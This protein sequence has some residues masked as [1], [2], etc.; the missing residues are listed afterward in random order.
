MIRCRTCQQDLIAY[1]QRKL[2]P[3]RRRQI[4]QHLEGCESCYRVYREYQHLAEELERTVPLIGRGYEPVSETRWLSSS[5]RRPQISSYGLVALVMAFMLIIPLTMGRPGLALAAATQPTP[6]VIVPVTPNNHVVHDS[7]T[8]VA[9]NLTPEPFP[10][11][12][13]ALNVINTP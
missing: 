6:H 5:V 8:A 1:I 13:P 10:K 11:A 9:F 4:A 2:K 3:A 7:V 12:L